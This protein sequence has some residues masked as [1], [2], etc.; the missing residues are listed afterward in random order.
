MTF[1]FRDRRDAGRQLAA[2]LSGLKGEDVVVLGLP[3]G[4]VPVAYEVASF[5]GAQLDVV[6]V[7]KL[8][9]P[10]QP[11]VAMGAVGEGGV[12]V[13]DADIVR[14]AG[15]NRSEVQAVR[16]KECA[17]VERRSSQLR[18]SRDRVPLLGRT[19]VV[20]DDGMATGSSA[21]AACKVVR[22]Y[23]V[24]RLV[25]AVPV[26]SRSALAVL[27]RVADE[28]VC[29][30]V[31]DRFSSVGQ[32]YRDFSQTSEEEVVSLLTAASMRQV[33]PVVLG[34]QA[35]DDPPVLDQDFDLP[36]GGA[37]L[38]G[39]VTVPEQARGLVVFAHGSGSGRH[40]PR[41]R[42]VASVLNQ[43]GLAT[44]L[45]DL[46]MPEESMDRRKVFDIELLGERLAESTSWLKDQP[47]VVPLRVGYFGASTGTAAA[48]WAA[49]KNQPTV[50]AIVSRGGRPD[51]AGPVLGRIRVPTLL[52]VGSN[53]GVV[54]EL[55]R[56]ALEQIGGP[57]ELELVPGA[58]HLFEEPGALEA[59]AELACDWFVKYLT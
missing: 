12:E 5:L 49:A 4:G 7:R 36:A 37:H 58:T 34:S 31:S 13:L 52:I 57:V 22:A 33:Q 14:M 21:L 23:G 20:V 38:V 2:R 48:M 3:R 41:N 10:F 40:S 26:A 46:L 54:L 35:L 27:A 43:A 29:V 16:E 55:N 53:D 44:F 19:A 9:V 30:E 28:V 59:V 51:L 24:S 17:E 32:W 56:R 15:V 25:L 39:H 47:E 18:G 11:E 45:L 50:S 8:G 6:V 1:R 42:L